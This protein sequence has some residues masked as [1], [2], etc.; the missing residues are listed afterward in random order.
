MIQKKIFFNFGK[1]KFRI[2]EAEKLIFDKSYKS[3]IYKL[4]NVENQLQWALRRLSFFTALNCILASQKYIQP[5]FGGW[6]CALHTL[7][8]VASFGGQMFLQVFSK[9]TIHELIS[10]KKGDFD[11]KSINRSCQ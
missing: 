7:C 6:N 8:T 9:R 5:I 4:Q 10:L 11:S 3:L 1:Q 2:A